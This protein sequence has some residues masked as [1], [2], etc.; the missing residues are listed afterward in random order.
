MALQLL[1]VSVPGAE[2]LIPFYPELLEIQLTSPFESETTN[3]AF[4]TKWDY[5]LSDQ[6][7]ISAGFRYDVE[8]QESVSSSDFALAPGSELPDPVEAGTMAD[9]LFPGLGMGPVVTG[10]VMQVNGYLLSLIAPSP[11]AYRDTDYE[12]FLPQVGV[13]YDIDANQSISAFYK[14]GYRAGGVD[15]PLAGEAPKEYDPE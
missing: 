14:T 13:T 3:Y 2:P 6:V 1:L 4:F 15:A 8:E 7:T 5:K 11:E 12:A 9:I 10:G